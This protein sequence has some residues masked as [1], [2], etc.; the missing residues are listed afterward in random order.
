MKK[1]FLLISSLVFSLLSGLTAQVDSSISS[2]GNS[3]S[4]DSLRKHLMII[5]SDEFEGRDTGMPGQKKAA[6]YLA[7]HFE[8]WGLE[9]VADSGYFQRFYIGQNRIDTAVLRM[10]E[11]E[12]LFLEDFYFFNP[13]V[14]EGTRSFKELRFL[15]YGIDDSLYSDYKGIEGNFD[16]I[17]IWEE[18]PADEEGNYLISGDQFNSEWSRDF[19]LKLQTAQ[20]K[21]V[22]NLFIVNK[23]YETVIGRLSGY[24]KMSRTT[25]W[26]EN[27]EDPEMSVFYISPKTASKMLG[28][29]YKPTRIAEKISRKR[30][31][32]TFVA[33]GNFEME[34]HKEQNKLSSENVLG[35]L[36]GSDQSEELLV[37]TAHYDHVGMRDGKIYNGADDDGSGTVALMEMARVFSKMS[38]EG[39][40]PRRSILFMA[41]S[42]EEKGLLG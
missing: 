12:F 15:G 36:E 28:R 19:S 7:N 23:D 22:K 3:I 1:T 32:E 24:L 29:K 4:E 30:V 18:E 39:M 16:N 21:G 17:L 41:V 5:A 40:V 31:S 11:E 37:I 35:Y 20:D 27:K 34:V 10:D 26:E 2:Y 25:L 9:E 38:Q 14:A 13:L 33:S 8:Q 6:R 42:G